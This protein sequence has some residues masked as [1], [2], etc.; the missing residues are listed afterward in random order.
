MADRWQPLV[1]GA[2][3]YQSDSDAIFLGGN[4]FQ[5]PART[6]LDLR[7]GV[8]TRDG[9]GDGDG[10]GD[11]SIQAFGRNVTNK[12]YWINVAHAI[13]TVVRYAG[14]PATNGI[15]IRYRYH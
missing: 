14:M 9:D 3:R 12:Y 4:Q 2:I 7:T 8:Q 13:D 1:G 6:L 11:W 5:L 10:D 15:T